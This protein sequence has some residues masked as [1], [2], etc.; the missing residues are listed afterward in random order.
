MKQNYN[1]RFIACVWAA[2]LLLLA[3]PYALLAQKVFKD[4]TIAS[5]NQPSPTFI[6]I[7]PTTVIKPGVGQSVRL[8]IQQPLANCVGLGTVL[9][10]EQNYIVTYT[11]RDSGIT[12]PADK[13]LQ[14]CQVM[15]NVQYFDGLGR[16]LQTVQVKGSPTFRDLVQP[17]IY[18]QFGREAVKYLPYA[19][20]PTA[21]SDG[22]YKPNALA[23]QASFYT[24]PS[25]PN[26]WNAPG[27]PKIAFPFA[28][29]AFEPSPLNRIVEEGA[30][31]DAW[32][33]TGKSGAT[34]P[35]HTD[36]T[37][38]AT[39]DAGSISTGSG[40]WAKLYSVSLDATGKP[41]LIDGGSYGASQ[42]YVTITK[43]E[44]WKTSDGKAGT[45][46]SYT[47]KEGNL[48]LKRVYNTNT[49]YISIYYV[50]SDLGNLT[51]VLSPKAEPDNGGITQTT[52]DKLCFQYRH[53]GRNRIVEKKVPAKGREYIVY[54]K[55]DQSVASQDSLQR[56]K[57]EWNFTK[58][59]ALGRV[60]VSGIWNNNNSAI[61]RA[62]L[63][64]L[65]DAQSIN[66]E[67]RDNTKSSSQYYTAES[68]PKS[69]ITTYLAVNYYDDYD[70]PNLPTNYDKRNSYS[71]M[72][73]GL[74]TASLANV[75]GTS[76]MLWTVKYYDDEG[77]VKKSF[78][79]HYFGGTNNLANYDETSFN[80]DFTDH[81]T[82]KT[83]E[84][85]AVNKP[86]LTISDSFDFDHVGRETKLWQQING[87]TKVLLAQSDYNEV[88]QVKTKH[89][90]SLNS[91]SSFLQDIS[92]QYNE[93]AWLVKDSSALFVMQLKYNDGTSPQYNGN[94]ANQYWGTGSNLSK[95]YAYTY[96]KLNRLT[97][98]ISNE[99]YHE[100]GIDYDKV[101]NIQH[102]TRNNPST[103]TTSSLTYNYDGNRLTGV[104]GLTG[105][106]LYQYDGNG[107]ISY[108]ARIGTNNTYNLLN[109]PNT[110]TGNG[111]NISYVYDAAGN[112][113]RRISAATGNTDYIDGIQYDNGQL[114]FIRTEHGRVLP[115]GSSF[116]Y[117]YNIGDKLG[118]AR[119]TFDTQSGTAHTVQQEDYYPFGVEIQRGAVVSPR[120]L[121]LYNKMELQEELGQYDYNKR[122]YDPII[123]RFTSIDP[124][125]EKYPY[126]T[127]YQFAGNE[128]P[129][130]MDMDGLEP[131]YQEASGRTVAARD[132][133]LQKPLTT[134]T[135]KAVLSQ[136]PVNGGDAT[137]AVGWYLEPFQTAFGGTNPD[138]SK[139]SVGDRLHALGTIVFERTFP[140]GRGGAKGGSIEVPTLDAPIMEGAPEAPNVQEI[141]I[142][143]SK[144]PESAAHAEQ[145]I[146]D[147]VSNEGVID[148]KG[149][150]ARRKEN[151]KGTEIQ[152]GKDRDEFPPAVIDNG[153]NG[154]SV[155]HIKPSD[156]RGA[157]S[158]IGHQIKK[159]PDGTRIRIV[160]KK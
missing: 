40:Y 26:T 91:G 35:G 156:N 62:D 84:H 144:H 123:G 14:T 13:T 108:D 122:F 109:L 8:Y 11:L 29:T 154:Q 145:A 93:R 16:P 2:L 95:N 140:I 141:S 46:E 70:V 157:G 22:S 51:Y 20:L 64:N 106:S 146:K 128:V 58:Y 9:S 130:A 131:A 30:P 42:L 85:Y 86:K 98:G 52:L 75:L 73:K 129:N 19:V 43:D 74:P 7:K 28:E 3:A 79:Q 118:N 48:V 142:S 97:A 65:V 66:W 113:L 15:T 150:S 72:T 67:S 24:N 116:N 105:T 160:V 101:G 34:N 117:E 139:A 21:A 126:Y 104:S 137:R 112:K 17:F 59:D 94:I 114:S 100:Q 78:V 111:K 37:I 25:N 39:N 45:K 68:F 148:R 143:R 121:Y 147:G 12:N 49:D 23:D 152:K 103:S 18:D 80:Y 54:N 38:Y 57:N 63:Q 99:G 120:N 44:N 33:L 151:L 47:D 36:K 119:L 155:K 41:S 90:H 127:P 77:R 153:N 31:G 56:I 76:N 61:S 83:R 60:I 55:L 107:N 27:I 102:L 71:S 134:A 81:V 69:S 92:Q 136:N 135:G 50:Y 125:A 87:G 138:G 89:L 82:S 159:L 110:I 115:S 96:D 5:W 149:A 158:S 32:Q 53:D 10:Q 1:R 4:T 124:L 88:G 133:Q 6:Q 132:G